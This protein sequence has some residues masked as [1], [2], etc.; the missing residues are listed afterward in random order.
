MPHAAGWK[1]AKALITLDRCFFHTLL[2]CLP[3]KGVNRQ[4][5]QIKVSDKTWRF[6]P[7]WTSW[8]TQ[9]IERLHPDHLGNRFW[10]ISS[11]APSSESVSGSS[12]RVCRQFQCPLGVSLHLEAAAWHQVRP[13]THINFVDFT[14]SRIGVTKCVFNKYVQWKESFSKRLRFAFVIVFLA[15][16]GRIPCCGRPE[17]YSSNIR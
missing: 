13:L 14:L 4:Q 2:P 17:S 11:C 16:M 10:S 12:P 3:R 6:C 7:W 15:E 8:G 1:Q 5:R 9:C